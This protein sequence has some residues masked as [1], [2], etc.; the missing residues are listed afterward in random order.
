MTSYLQIVTDIRERR[1]EVLD[2][3]S[4][5]AFRWGYFDSNGTVPKFS[6]T[7]DRKVVDLV[8]TTVPYGIESGW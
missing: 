2:P 4:G 7:L 5:L 8:P 3:V 1:F 6:R